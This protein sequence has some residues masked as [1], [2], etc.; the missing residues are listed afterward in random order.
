M[1]GG[2]AQGCCPLGGVE[3]RGRRW[4]DPPDRSENQEMQVLHQHETPSLL[5]ATETCRQAGH[6]T[7]NVERGGGAS[8]VV[9]CVIGTE[10]RE[11]AFRPPNLA[12]AL[13]LLLL[14]RPPHG[15]V[16][17]GITAQVF[18]THHQ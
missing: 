16:N 1:G 7:A 2:R 10:L 8:P 6:E 15:L 14:G 11:R 12:G 5:T 3:G 17:L 4:I 13:S 9:I 18:S